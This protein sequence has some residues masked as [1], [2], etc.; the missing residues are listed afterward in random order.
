MIT[1]HFLKGIKISS[2][3][4][5]RSFDKEIEEIVEI[6][7]INLMCWDLLSSNIDGKQLVVYLNKSD[8]AQRF[9]RL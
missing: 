5:S 3:E 9:T 4:L 7:L 8:P 2:C 1:L 6:I